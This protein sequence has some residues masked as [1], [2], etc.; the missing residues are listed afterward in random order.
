[1]THSATN[2]NGFEFKYNKLGFPTN[3]VEYELT[4]NTAISQGTPVVI[5]TPATGG[6][7]KVSALSSGTVNKQKTILGVMAETFTTTTNP[8]SAQTYGKVYDNPFNVYKVSFAN[9]YDGTVGTAS[10]I[11]TVL[12]TG[13]SCGTGTSNLAGALVYVYEGPAK[14]DIRTITSNTSAGVATVAPGFSA[15]P[16]TLSKIIITAQKSSGGF[17]AYGLNVGTVGAKC[18]TADSC[19]KV[20]CSV[21]PGVA[22][23]LNV[24]AVDPANLT[25]D[26]MFQPA[27]CT[28]T[29]G[30]TS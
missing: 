6:L 8:T 7:A 12:N 24:L 13:V 20:D 4:P 10:S 26:V 17:T 5:S 16:T 14:G 9:H 19:R 2:T 11:A 25:M 18:S 3:P 23:Y 30:V 21:A 27:K 1:M 15:S 29:A 28:L 22:G